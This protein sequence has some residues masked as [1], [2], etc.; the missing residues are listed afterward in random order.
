K[1]Q[2]TASHITEVAR[3]TDAPLKLKKIDQRSHQAQAEHA[4]ELRNV[5]NIRKNLEREHAHVSTRLPTVDGAPRNLD[6]TK[7]G[8][9][10][11]DQTGPLVD[12]IDKKG[13]ASGDDDGK[14]GYTAKGDTIKLNLPK[15]KLP[16][17]VS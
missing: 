7:L 9:R 10:D 13:K 14:K 3:Q 2:L 8:T 15:V 11:P 1:T 12:R 4:K 5:D 6:Q 16:A 17:N